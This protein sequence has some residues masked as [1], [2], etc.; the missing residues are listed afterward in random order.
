[1]LRSTLFIIL[2]GFWTYNILEMKN[3]GNIL[4]TKLNDFKKKLKIKSCRTGYW[5][6]PYSVN[7]IFVPA[8]ADITAFDKADEVK[9]KSTLEQFK[10]M[11]IKYSLGEVILTI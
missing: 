3:G 7:F 2:H 9:L 5:N 1:L 10:G 11:D 4:N 8:W 6:Q